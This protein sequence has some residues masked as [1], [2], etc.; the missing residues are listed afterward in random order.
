MAFIAD[1][2]VIIPWFSRNQAT[3]YTDRLYKRL[4]KD[5]LMVPSVWPYEFANAL[6]VLERRKIVSRTLVDEVVA[7]AARLVT[8]IDAPPAA[9]S[10]LLSLARRHGL[11]AYDAA[12]LE[13]AQRLATPLATR[14]SPLA[15]AAKRLDLLVD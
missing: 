13:L 1:N 12:Y 15:A 9:P 10:L 8:R 3:P 7:R 2:S 11:S 5:D 6:A 4:E 14:D